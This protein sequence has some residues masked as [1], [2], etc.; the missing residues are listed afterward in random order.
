MHHRSTKTIARARPPA[1]QLALSTLAAVAVALTAQP[2]TAA[3]IADAAGDFLPTYAGPRGGDLDVLAVSAVRSG[4]DWVTLTGE[5]A[6]AIG[7]TAGAAYIWGI[8]RGAGIEPFPTFDP[9]T[10]QGVF[11]D[12][13]VVLRPDGTG[14]LTDLITG[15]TRQLDPSTITIAGATISVR[16]ARSLLPDQGLGFAGYLYNLW[17]RYAPAVVDPGSNTQISDFA[18]DARSFAAAV[19]EAASWTLMLSGFA[20]TGAMLRRRRAPVLTA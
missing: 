18:P 8:N 9:P 7:T 4:L 17:P 10:G 11:F 19:P 14:S 13:Y 16:L 20:A 5:H 3:T 12:S 15:G 2:A 1:G 6:A